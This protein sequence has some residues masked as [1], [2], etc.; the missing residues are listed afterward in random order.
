MFAGERERTLLDRDDL[1]TRYLSVD[2]QSLMVNWDSKKIRKNTVV[3]SIATADQLT[4][5][6]FGVNVNFDPELDPVEVQ[7]DMLRF[8][9]PKLAAPFRRYARAWL[10]AD[11][12]AAARRTM[13]RSTSLPKA[14]EKK[15]TVEEA[16]EETYE[17]TL[18]REDME[19]GGT[20]AQP[21]KVPA[22]G[23]LLHEQYVMYAH[24][25]LVTRLLQRA[26]KIRFSPTRSLE[27]GPPSWRR[28]MN[29]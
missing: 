14:G 3:R 29:G 4:G 13:A 2:R 6:V 20:P 8:G 7:V 23:M 26:R 28:S 19:S 17:T 9:D 15:R 21:S 1:G 18:E 5:Y 25:Q 27:S 10:P 11:W 24:I 12:D 16:I 22:K